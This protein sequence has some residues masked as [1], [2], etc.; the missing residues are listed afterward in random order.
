MLHM[1]YRCN[2]TS[3][4]FSAFPSTFSMPRLENS[5]I[6]GRSGQLSRSIFNQA[7]PS[8]IP[9][10]SIL[11]ATTY[12]YSHTQSVDWSSVHCDADLILSS[13]ADFNPPPIQLLPGAHIT[14]PSDRASI[15]SWQPQRKMRE[16][17]IQWPLGLGGKDLVGAGITAIVA[18]LD[19]VVKFSGPSELH[20]LEREKLVY[21]RLGRNHSGIVRYFGVR[22]NAIILQFASQTSIRQYFSRQKKPVP[23]ALKLRW[24][25]QLFDAL[26]DFAGSAI[27]DLP[28]LIC[29]ETSHELPGEDISPRTELFALGSAT[30]EIIT[31][32]KPYQDLP[33]HEISAAFLEGRYPDLKSISAFG[34]IIMGCWRH[35]YTTVEEA[36]QDVKLEGTFNAFSSYV[37]VSRYAPPSS[38]TGS[39]EEQEKEVQ[40]HVINPSS[41]RPSPRLQPDYGL[42]FK[43]DAFSREQLQKLQT[44]IS[45]PFADSSSWIVEPYNMYLLFFSSEVISRAAGFNM[46][47][48]QNALTQSVVLRGLYTLFRSVGR[49]NELH[50]EI[51]GFSISQSGLGVRIWG[52]YAII[53]GKD[54][55]FDQHLIAQFSISPTAQADERWTAYCFVKNVYDLWLPK[56]YKR[57]CSI[58]DMLPAD[59]NFGDSEKLTFSHSGLSQQVDDCSLANEQ[60]I[61]GSEPSV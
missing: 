3:N 9:A 41:S 32:S 38:S 47:D 52:H 58:I 56:H 36:F 27:D 49:E 29:Y 35:N 39:T 2:S 44:F 8:P 28:P 42:G 23:L 1:Q 11:S 24:V 17:V 53:N 46:A 50:R 43:R 26:G 37:A 31:G 4:K 20:F 51:N 14:S 34:N 13:P 16:L 12:A 60:V 61:P 7:K 18:R 15:P 6:M 54:V 33:D 21:Q 59:L 40:A 25:E 30:H 19:A 45:D 10:L 57:I 48:R 5:G 22:E 55:E